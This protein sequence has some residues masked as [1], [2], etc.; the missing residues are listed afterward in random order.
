MTRLSTNSGLMIIL[1]LVVRFVIKTF[2]LSNMGRQ[3]LISHAIGKSHKKHFDRNQFFFKLKNSTV[4]NQKH[5]VAVVKIILQLIRK[6][7]MSL[8]CQST[9]YRAYAKTLL[10]AEN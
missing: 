6:K 5:A 4:N 9:F 2:K 3:A 10:K 1:L 8:S 7:K